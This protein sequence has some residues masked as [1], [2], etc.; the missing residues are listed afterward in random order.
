MQAPSPT[1]PPVALSIAGSD[2][3]GGAGI[4]ADLQT[5]AAH[6]VYGTTAITAVTAQNTRGVEDSHVLPVEVVEAQYDA[7]LSD[8]D[9]KAI[10][11]GMLATTPIVEAV[12]DRVADAGLPAVVDPVMVA[13]S[14]DRLLTED[15][16]AA[17][18]D[19]I[20]EATLVTPNADEASVLTGTEVTGRESAERAG[21]AL[22][23][24]GADAALIKGGHVAGDPIRDVLVTPER[25]QVFEHGRV[26]T[27]ATH[28]SG[29]ALSSAIA[30]L[31]A[32]GEPLDAAVGEGTDFLERAVRHHYDVGQGP[33]AV[34]HLVD[35]RV[36]TDGDD[37]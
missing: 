12:A 24:M 29:C 23:E 31:L 18:E 33:G 13:T 8:F 25:T 4:Q 6:G 37:G 30:A 19:L 10:K 32:R 20:A 26:D 7:V 28:G 11:T 17:Y 14:G 35:L 22:L 21:D 34:N 3:G 15:A 9:V 1:E 36:R 27:E 2:S 16:E 5:M